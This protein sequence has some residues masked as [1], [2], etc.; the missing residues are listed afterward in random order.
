VTSATSSSSLDEPLPYDAANAFAITSRT[1]AGVMRRSVVV[2]MANGFGDQCDCF[3]VLPPE[4]RLLYRLAERLRKLIPVV[5]AEDSRRLRELSAVASQTFA[6]C[7]VLSEH[8]SSCNSPRVSGRPTSVVGRGLS[9]W[10][11]N[12]S[13]ALQG[14][15]LLLVDTSMR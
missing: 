5:A 10:R 2:Q 1:C 4:G 9:Q 13:P 6:A 15:R 11:A 7:R 3:V 8:L 12:S 14:A